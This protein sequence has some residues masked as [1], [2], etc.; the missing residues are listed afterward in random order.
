MDKAIFSGPK[1]PR[2]GLI[3]GLFKQSPTRSMS[4]A[5]L[6]EHRDSHDVTELAV[7][8]EQ[9]RRAAVEYLQAQYSDI[10]QNFDTSVVPLRK[11]RKIVLADSDLD[12]LS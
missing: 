7:V 5:G 11:K 4:S 6:H 2:Y 3:R 9:E 10:Q 1:I 8:I 12:G